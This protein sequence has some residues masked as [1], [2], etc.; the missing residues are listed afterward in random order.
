MKKYRILEEKSTFTGK[1]RFYI[2][3]KIRLLFWSWWRK[4]THEEF[5]GQVNYTF[6]DSFDTIEEARRKLQYFNEKFEKIIHDDKN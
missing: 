2:Q 4:T 1:S 3:Q 6:Y 5:V